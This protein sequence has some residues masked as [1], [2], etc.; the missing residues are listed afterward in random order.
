MP[1]SRWQSNQ[2]PYTND[3]CSSL[4]L[5][6]CHVTDFRSRKLNSQ[7]ERAIHEAM[8]ELDNA[9]AAKTQPM[10]PTKRTRSTRAAIVTQPRTKPVRIAPAP[11]AGGTAIVTHTKNLRTNNNSLAVQNHNNPRP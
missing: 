5:H 3:N 7:L 1:G 9:A 6:P 8:V 2:K 4:L 10:S 11:P